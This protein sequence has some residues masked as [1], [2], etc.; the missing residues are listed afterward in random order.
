VFLRH[1]VARFAPYYN[2]LGWTSSWEWMD[3]WSA[4]EVNQI[5]EYLHSIDPWRRPL[6]AHDN[7][8]STFTDWLTFSMRQAPS[9]NIFMSNSRHAGQQQTAD[10][11]GSGGIG[12]P[13]IDHP[14]IGSEDIW[15]SPIAERFSGWAVPRNRAEAR[16]AAWESKWR[17][18]C[19]FIPNGTPG[20]RLLRRP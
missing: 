16:R 4:S 5:M 9:R 7:S 12:N 13:F 6:S 15:E 1:W 19:R 3:I 14:I 11:D 18:S 20:R 17:G 8:H 2:F 10:P